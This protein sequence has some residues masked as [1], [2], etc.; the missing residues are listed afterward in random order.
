MLRVSAGSGGFKMQSCKLRLPFTDARYRM[1]ER[2]H[3]SGFWTGIAN[4][5]PLYAEVTT[6]TYCA[7]SCRGCNVE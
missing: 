5:R 3:L 7:V 4:L 2:R 6:P 1:D